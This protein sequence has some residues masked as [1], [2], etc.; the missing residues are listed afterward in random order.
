MEYLIKHSSIINFYRLNDRFL[1]SQ[2]KQYNINDKISKGILFNVIEIT[3]P[4][5]I[6][7]PIANRII[8]C[9]DQTYSKSNN[10][11]DSVNFEIT[12]KGVNDTLGKITRNGET[13]WIGN[14]NS[15]IVLANDDK[16]YLTQTGKAE[17]Y[18]FRSEKLEHIT[19]T[20]TKN[21]EPHP[22]KT[23]S[24]IISGQIKPGDKILLTSPK[25]FDY[26]SKERL[27]Q[28]IA[29]SNI[30]HAIENIAIIL[31]KEKITDVSLILFEFNTKEEFGSRII[32]D[33]KEIIYLDKEDFSSFWP[34]I[35]QY[36]NNIKPYWENFK[37]KI[38]GAY[39]KTAHFSK[40]K[41]TPFLKENWS[42]VKKASKDNLDKIKDKK[43]PEE[44]FN[45]SVKTPL[46]LKT[47]K[48]YQV[49][50][51]SHKKRKSKFVTYLEK[52]FSDIKN[53]IVCTLEKI[54]SKKNHYV[55]YIIVVVILA[56]AL[57]FSMIQLRKKQ[58]LNKEIEQASIELNEAKAKFQ[59]EAKLAI[60]YNENEKATEL[61]SEIIITCEKFQDN[62]S[63]KEK[64][65]ELLLEAR[66]ELDKLTKTTRINTF[67]E[68][69][70][71]N[72]SN[73]FT[74]ANDIIYSFE[75]NSNKILYYPISSNS[76]TKEILLPDKTD[77]IESITYLG[78]NKNIIVY[79]AENQMYKT[80]ENDKVEKIYP[81][82]G[83]WPTIDK[84]ITYFGSIYALDKN[85]NQIIRFTKSTEGY[86]KPTNYISDNT[87]IIDAVSFAIDGSV[88]LL[89][90]NGKVEKLSRG[91]KVEF[92]IEEIPNP[93][94]KITN[95]KKIYTDTE[96]KSI[97]ILDNHRIIEFD[98]KGNFI[99]QYIFNNLNNIDD[100][101]ISY[102]NNKFF[103]LDSNKIYE[104]NY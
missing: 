48:K 45:N 14:L 21:L 9:I 71:F 70:N 4:I 18:L 85:Q 16:L 26:F 95:P 80:Q 88:Y 89:K 27:K 15:V 1:T 61:L 53:F 57:I 60:L 83:Q 12:I 74:I 81:I 98:K 67:E 38:N 101:I 40:E 6:S 69:T 79:T 44:K 77:S 90:Q 30:Y 32:E 37:K 54:T 58:N 47:E 93:Q 91:K 31:K 86:E 7:S 20:T 5:N 39:N 68:I 43:K 35:K 82:R 59:D 66:G 46:E 52:L 76:N 23:F 75:Q 3:N 92:N 63:L 29:S 94:S 100:F 13:S 104:I 102:E 78:D 49:H 25:L 103:I 8:N 73:Q 41:V 33:A 84:F 2:I 55:I 17:A 56:S 96:A 10:V 24:N 36:L 65:N 42:K 51:Y 34:Q 28:I 19:E 99:K 87:D 50:D 11:S 72:N 64:A 97:W 62:P 22:L